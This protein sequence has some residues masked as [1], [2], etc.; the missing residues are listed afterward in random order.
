[1]LTPIFELFYETKNITRDVSPYVTNIEYTDYEHGSSDEL[2]IT[3]EDSAN[4]WKSSWLPSK[5]D[6]LRA[7]LGYQDEKLLNC[8]SFEIDELEYSAPPDTVTVKGLAT[9][10]KKPLRQKN[11]AGYENKT[12]KQ[13]AKEIA[14][15][16]GLTL[17]WNIEDIKVDRI[18]QNKE[19]D[20]TF[21][22]KLAEQYGYIFKIA[23]GNLV[24]YSVQKLKSAKTTQIFNKSDLTSINFREKTSG[25]YKS[26]QVSYFDPKKKK[27]LTASAKNDSVVKGDTLK[28]TSRCTSKKLALVQAKAALNRSDTKI[29]GSLEFTG[30]PY[31]IAG[32]NIEIKGVGH[33][34]GKYHIV[35]AKH[36]FDRISGYKTYCE[37]SSC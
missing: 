7:Y 27:K 26:V 30:N 31:L 36:T 15:R 23:E 9:G 17:I 14:D 20:L 28:I 10:I 37:V 34:S 12:L 16:Q 1:M 6:S 35:Q 13:I 32:L 11:S 18:T 24:F 8:G 25:K 2:T 29:E 22:T 19:K 5:G 33:F 4:L 3:F 21:L